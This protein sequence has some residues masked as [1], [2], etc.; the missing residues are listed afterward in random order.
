MI[1]KKFLKHF[2]LFYNSIFFDKY[3]IEFINN[4]K[5]KI[6]EKKLKKKTF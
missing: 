2:L 1:F 4:N 3:E 6:F 5:K